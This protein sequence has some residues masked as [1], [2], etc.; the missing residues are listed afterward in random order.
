M[1]PNNPRQ[2]SQREERILVAIRESLLPDAPV[3]QETEPQKPPKMPPASWD[4]RGTSVDEVKATEPAFG[5]AQ[6][7]AGEADEFGHHISEPSPSLAPALDLVESSPRSSGRSMTG[8]LLR[9]FIQGAF[10]V[11]IISA[12][13]ALPSYEEQLQRNVSAARVYLESQL[14]SLVHLAQVI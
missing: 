9:T 11:G 14:Q 12:V 8:R 10:A 7:D 2:L 1:T 3:K 5:P 4:W 6:P 13:L